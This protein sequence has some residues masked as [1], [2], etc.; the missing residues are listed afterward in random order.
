MTLSQVPGRLSSQLLEDRPANLPGE[1][2]V[3]GGRQPS[4]VNAV[5][6]TPE[7]AEIVEV[8]SPADLNLVI[9]KRPI[10]LRVM[11][12]WDRERICE[13]FGSLGIS[14]IFWPLLLDAPQ[15]PRVESIPGALLVVLH[16]LRFS[17]DPLHLLS[18]QVGFLLLPNL[19]I[20]VEEA[21]SRESFPGLTAWL[22]A[23]SG[24]VEDRDLD[25][26]LHFLIDEILD[27]HFPML[28]KIS[29]QLDQLEESALQKPTPSVLER[30][31]AHRGNVRV[32][33]NQ[34][35]PLRHQLT[36]LLR[37]RQQLLG[38]EALVGFSEMRELVEL[39]FENAELVRH[40]C[41]AITEAYSA[42][43]GNR[44]NQVM[45]TL[46]ILTS[47]F[48]PIT[49]IAGV[50]GM[51]FDNMPELHWEFGY[52]YSLVLMALAAGLQTM[53]LWKRGWFQDWT[54]TR[55]SGATPD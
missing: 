4:R 47:I 2:F 36:L 38:D 24:A 18:S 13:L 55:R 43:I 34:I 52:P 35:W 1:L 22:Q 31:F 23:R 12:L 42:S 51:N 27:D 40:Q 25:D 3:Y 8:H 41:D 50:Y 30:T 5:V 17:S 14:E 45:K 10:W 21:P 11:G 26:I 32:I 49:F 33:R 29:H 46:T 19:L 39:L 20:T 16:R 28:E 37:Q 53:W 44:M 54:S 48:A 7:A 15:R 9:N 6:F